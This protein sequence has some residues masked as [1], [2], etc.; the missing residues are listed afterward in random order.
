[1]AYN[2]EYPYTDPN[3]YNDDWLLN[4]MKEVVTEWSKVQGDWTTQQEAFES[5]KTFVSN[6]FDNLNVQT[7]INNKLD[8]MREDG[9]L[10]ALIAPYLPFVTPQMFG[11]RSDGLTDDT[12]AIRDAIT[13]AQQGKGIVLF[14]L[15]N[16]PMIFTQIQVPSGITLKGAGGVLKL[17]DNYCIDETISYY[18]IHTLGVSTPKNI[19]IQD[20]I[21]DGNKANNT[22]Y[23]VADMITVGGENIRVVNNK[24]LNPPDSGIMFSTVRNSQCNGNVIDGAPDCGIY[25][26]NNDQTNNMNSEC[27]NNAISN[28]YTAIA[29]KRITNHMRCD[30]NRIVSCSFGIT[31]EHASTSTD[32]STDNIISN[33]MF[34]NITAWCVILRGSFNEVVL[35][36]Q[37]T[38]ANGFCLVESSSNCSITSNVI[39]KTNATG[40]YAAILVNYRP[41]GEL[42]CKNILISN[43]TIDCKDATTVYNVINIL[44]A[45]DKVHHIKVLNN[46]ISGS[47]NVGIQV[48]AAN[49]CSLIGNF[50]ETRSTGRSIIIMNS[51]YCIYSLNT[52]NTA[53]NIQGLTIIDTL[54]NGNRVYFL[55]SGGP[56]V[57]Q[58]NIGDILINR[59]YSESSNFGWYKAN[60]G[61]LKTFISI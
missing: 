34:D 37:A 52:I 42:E 16:D 21:I 20:L 10:M 5:L 9:S 25:I 7:E 8:A 14:P 43:N 36:N 38:N 47:G 26:N 41:D 1:M 29:M 61:T 40:N 33:N 24:I 30:G 54:Q 3:R 57:S 53:N 55:A 31:N 51:Q 23:L 50:V 19:T 11:A 4:K 28:C 35:G 32:Y 59:D 39:D 56:D 6:Y 46:I 13:A 22:K 58:L 27:N 60:D 17:K 15:E 12:Q 48:S 44:G 45:S 18:L 49:N 2:Y